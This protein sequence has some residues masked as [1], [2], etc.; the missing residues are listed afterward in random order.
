M[1][2]CAG[3]SAG[4]I[5]PSQLGGKAVQGGNETMRAMVLLAAA[6]FIAGC[7]DPGACHAKYEHGMDRYLCDDLNQ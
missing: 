7:N 4:R 2:C 3:F 6:I 1:A 5:A